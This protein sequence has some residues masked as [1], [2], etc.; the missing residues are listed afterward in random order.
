M[1]ERVLVCGG[2]DYSNADWLNYVLD[3]FRD[4]HG[5]EC[6]IQGGAK[7]A[8]QLAKRWALSQPLPCIE[9][10]AAWD[11]L[12]KAAGMV[13]NRWMIEHCAPDCVIAFA[14][15]RGTAGM[16]D[17]AQ[18]IGKPVWRIGERIGVKQG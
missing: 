11:A 8:D 5:V 13:R 12:G 17:L 18:S 3:C 7:G 15:G 4:K 10:P 16:I 14:G 6:V 2:R 1:G 9:V